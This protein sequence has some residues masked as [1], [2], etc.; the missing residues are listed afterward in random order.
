MDAPTRRLI[1]EI[2]LR[3]AAKAVDANDFMAAT[4]AVTQAAELD[5]ALEPA[6]EALAYLRDLAGCSLCERR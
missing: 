5:G 6:R 1:A 2:Q 4:R 3:Q